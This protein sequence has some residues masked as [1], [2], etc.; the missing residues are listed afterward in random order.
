MDIGCGTSVVGDGSGDLDIS[1]DVHAHPLSMH[2]ISYQYIIGVGNP[3]ADDP[4]FY[5]Q[6][7]PRYHRF[8]V[9]KPGNVTIDSCASMMNVGM[10]SKKS[11]TVVFFGWVF[12]L[13]FVRRSGTTRAEG[14]HVA[15][16]RARGQTKSN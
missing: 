14:P 11:G 2:V 4:G 10:V 16:V 1:K 12:F 6:R 7:C 15:H 5:P 13:D 9:T 8:S 3:N